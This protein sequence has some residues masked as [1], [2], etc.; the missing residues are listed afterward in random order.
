MT[1]F[2][3]LNKEHSIAKP[4]FSRWLV[5]PAALA[6]H[7]CIGQIYA[8]SVFNRPLTQIIGITQ[9]VEQDWTLTTLGW[10]FSIALVTLGASAALFGKWLERVGPRMAM[11]ASALC[12]SGGFFIAAFG[13]H[14]HQI[15]LVYL[16]HGV[17][18]GIGLALDIYRQ[19]LP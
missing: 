11:F 12:F 16:G 7:L 14:L 19:C 6:I 17:I 1:F 18:G 10:I 5:P 15:W 4:G 3:F 9:S 13:V 2:S 8:Y